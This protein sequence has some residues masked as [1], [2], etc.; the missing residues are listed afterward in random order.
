MFIT[1]SASLPLAFSTPISLLTK[2][3]NRLR[4]PL[5]IILPLSV[6]IRF[7]PTFF[8]NIKQIRDINTLRFGGT[9]LWIQMLRPV[10]FWRTF[11][12]PLIF[13]S[14][15]SSDALAL[16][17]TL[18]GVG[19][20]GGLKMIEKQRLGALDWFVLSVWVGCLWGAYS[21]QTYVLSTVGASYVH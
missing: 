5:F 20:K 13:S 10:R 3:L 21:W 16:S 6:A 2:E 8:S 19:T 11:C 7:L 14:L 17:S 15:H 12:V 4:L 18:K 9:P 1:L